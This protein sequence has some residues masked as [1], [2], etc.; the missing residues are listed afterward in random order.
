MSPVCVALGGGRLTPEG[1]ISADLRPRVSDGLVVDLRQ[2]LPFRSSSIDYFHCEHALEHLSFEEG[3]RLLTE[4]RR[5]LKPTGC[6]RIA[7]PDASR[8]AN[9]LLTTQ[10][11]L[12]L[13]PTLDGWKRFV[14]FSNERWGVPPAWRTEPLFA[15]NRVFNWWGHRF[16]Y[17]PELL[18]EL[19]E[20]LGFEVQRAAVGSSVDPLLVGIERHGEDST[21]EFN[22]IQTFVLEAR[23]RHHE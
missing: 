9:L 14:R 1:W 11:Q 6:I 18:T 12:D 17:T 3:T 4:A 8:F 22:E 15:V 16:L 2:D 13:D 7:T 20:T 5:C 23:I 19:L 21:Q 10:G